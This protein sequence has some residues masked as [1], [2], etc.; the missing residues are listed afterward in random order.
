MKSDSIPLVARLREAAALLLTLPGIVTGA[1][2]A[3]GHGSLSVAAL[4]AIV[5]ACITAGA[6]AGLA[7]VRAARRISPSNGRHVAANHS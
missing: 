1:A 2:M 3:H 7:L 5:S 4:M 6:I